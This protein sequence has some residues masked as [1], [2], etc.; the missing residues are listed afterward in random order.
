MKWIGNR[1][2]I[3]PINKEYTH[4]H[5]VKVT[6]SWIL[7]LQEVY[8]IINYCTI[9]NPLTLDAYNCKKKTDSYNTCMIQHNPPPKEPTISSETETIYATTGYD[10]QVATPAIR[11]SIS[12]SINNTEMDD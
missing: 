10:A 8:I 5:V 3:S 7:F 9:Y 6:I 12:I 4:G 11:W 2:H 1:F